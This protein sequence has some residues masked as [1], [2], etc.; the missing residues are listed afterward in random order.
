MLL[1]GVCITLPSSPF[2]DSRSSWGRTSDRRFRPIKWPVQEIKKRM[3]PQDSSLDSKMGRRPISRCLFATRGSIRE[4]HHIT[5]RISASIRGQIPSAGAFYGKMTPSVAYAAASFCPRPRFKNLLTLSLLD[6]RRQSCERSVRRGL[7]Y[8]WGNNAHKAS[9]RRLHAS[10]AY[11]ICVGDLASVACA[12]A[13]TRSA[14][15]VQW[16][17]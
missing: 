6:A 15:A 3:D 10:L 9:T 5:P 2:V 11:V 16:G 14:W 4:V 8:S 17:T 1:Q 13:S 12:A 7:R